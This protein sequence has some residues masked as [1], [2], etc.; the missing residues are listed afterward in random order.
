M[1]TDRFEQAKLKVLLKQ[2]DPHG[3]GTLQEKSVH[4]VM[5][6]Y[7]EPN[8]DYHEV[9]IEG[10]IADIYTGERIIEIQNGNFNRLRDKLQAFLP[11]YPVTVVLPIP[12]YKWLV[13]IDEESGALSGRR[14]SPVTGT[15]YHAFPELYKIKA[16]LAHPNLSFAFP[17]IDIDEY[18]LLNGWS[19]D[20]KKGSQRYDRLPLALYDEVCF[21]RKEDFIQVIP[22]ELEEAFTVKEFARA[23]GISRDLAQV[24]L[25]ILH[26]M[27]LVERNGKRGREYLYGVAEGSSKLPD[28]IN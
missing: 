21:E 3:F 17:L 6:L 11:L 12:H 13:W 22:Y 20:R 4:A 27:Q 24:T 8:M 15:V 2:H 9:P 5:K 26:H 16:F 18:R 23:A 14:K 10:Y 19:R 1:N 25:H 7:Y 28:E